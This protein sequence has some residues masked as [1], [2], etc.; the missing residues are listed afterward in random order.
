VRMPV[1]WRFRFL[2]AL[3]PVLDLLLC[4]KDLFVAARTMGCSHHE[5]SATSSG[6]VSSAIA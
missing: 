2:V 6:S 1:H 4:A 3:P 5:T